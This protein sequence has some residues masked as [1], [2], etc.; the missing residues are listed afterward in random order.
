LKAADLATRLEALTTEASESYD[1]EE[2]A[3]RS[4]RRALVRAYLLWRDCQASPGFLDA[5]YEAHGIRGYKL[6]EGNRPNFNPLL[7]LVFRKS[8]ELRN[9][10]S[11]I[12]QRAAALSA[13][14][15][16]HEDNPKRYRKDPEAKLLGFMNENGGISGL[17]KLDQDARAARDGRT[18]PGGLPAPREKEADH[19]FGV[20]SLTAL[21][22][23]A[24]DSAVSSPGIASFVPSRPVRV[25][26]DEMLVLLAKRQPDGTVVVVGS[27]NESEALA[28]TMLHARDYTLAKLPSPFRVLVETVRTQMY[29]PFA[30]P[31]DLKLRRQWEAR[32]ADHSH[33][34]TKQLPTW[35]GTGKGKPVMAVKKLVVRAADESILLSSSALA[36]SVVTLCKP[37]KG[38]F[39]YVASKPE[40]LHRETAQR[41]REQLA[42]DPTLDEDELVIA[43]GDYHYE[44]MGD[45]EAALE[46]QGLR[47]VERMIETTE[48]FSIGVKPAAARF[49]GHGRYRG[50]ARPDRWII[51]LQREHEQKARALSFYDTWRDAGAVLGF[52]PTFDF[53]GW[54]PAW[55]VE[56][57]PVWFGQLRE[58]LLDGWFASFGG[59]TQFARATNQA[60]RFTLDG[61]G[62]V[63]GFNFDPRQD[64]ASPS[65][66]MPLPTGHEASWLH[67]SRDIAPALYNVADAEIVG[68][69]TLSGDGNALLISYST[70]VA[71]FS[72]AVPTA[73]VTTKGVARNAAGFVELRYG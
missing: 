11:R 53:S 71:A 60:M 50:H 19:E 21:R 32:N 6:S 3:T 24:L 26:A 20:E 52:Q 57:E 13:L 12:G 25:G 54:K 70:A 51:E 17:S 59:S 10:A 18:G 56:V 9:N 23:A 67:L 30:L 65:A 45:A 47:L 72:I 7:R 29:P 33:I 34:T 64:G 37:I 43:S 61:K 16:E 4:H 42:A 8:L 69:A 49:P 28:A 55:Q 1:A 38:A 66:S 39:P 36:A 15:A 73:S 35:E 46:G 62:L 2:L 44:P 58:K 5:Q 14:H 40:P 48:I 68:K 63:I 22:K 27:T 41:I 31:A